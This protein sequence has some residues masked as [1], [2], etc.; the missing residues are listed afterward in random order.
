MKGGINHDNIRNTGIKGMK[1]YDTLNNG[2]Q[3]H[4]ATQYT[5]YRGY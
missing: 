1:Q 4:E 3:M 2:D 5:Q